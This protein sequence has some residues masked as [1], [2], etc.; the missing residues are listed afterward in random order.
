MAN[1]SDRLR[2]AI[3]DRYEI[4]SEIGRGGMAVVYRARDLKNHRE[5]AIKVLKPGLSAVLGAERFLR[6]MGITARF[7]HPNIVPLL[8]SGQFAGLLYYVMPYVTGESLRERIDREIQLPVA[9]ALRIT[10]QVSSALEYAHRQQVI[11]RDIKPEN[12]LLHEGVAMVADFGMALAVTTAGGE[13]LTATGI[14]VGT[15]EYMSPE[16]ATGSRKL[17]GRSDI[18]GLGCVLYEMLTGEPPHAASTPH[19]VIAKRLSDTVTP[20]RRLRGIVSQPIERTLELALAKVPAN[21]FE[22]A[23]DFAQA[24]ATA[25]ADSPE[26]RRQRRGTWVLPVVVAAGA[27]IALLLWLAKL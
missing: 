11:H 5:V 2:E 23:Q 14:T 12:I 6:E 13:R 7:N 26:P 10:E 1:L 16:Q 4:G 9:E 8:D 18:Y 19:A 22:T 25:S 24:L 21:R 27:L 17:D 3:A 20:A 15:P